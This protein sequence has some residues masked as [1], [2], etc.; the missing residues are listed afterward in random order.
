MVQP[1]LPYGWKKLRREL[2]QSQRCVVFLDYDGTLTS[3]VRDPDRAVLSK[4]MRSVLEKLARQKRFDLVVLSG[5]K[6]RQLRRLVRIERIIYAGSHGYEWGSAR[7]REVYERVRRFRPVIHR[8]ANRLAKKLLGIP[9]AW[10]EDKGFTC[11]VHYRKC[12]PR[13]VLRVLRVCDEVTGSVL[14]KDRIRV[15]N[16]KKVYELCPAIEWDKGKAVEWLL[17]AF[18]RIAG[19]RSVIYLGDDATDEDA[20]RVVKQLGGWGIRVGWP[21]KSTEASYVVNGIREV[22]SSLTHLLTEFQLDVS[23]K[24]ERGVKSEKQRKF[25]SRLKEQKAA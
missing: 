25:L 14:F 24:S 10:I 8:L 18:P 16:G 15:I 19:K 12:R 20:F 3:I 6:L 13:D 9:G 21:E 17:R 23:A 22:R 1:F 2:R 7:P 4:S 11:S 5:R